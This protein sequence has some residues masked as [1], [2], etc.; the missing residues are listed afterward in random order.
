[1]TNCILCTPQPTQLSK[2]S[3]KEHRHA[4]ELGDSANSAV[5]EHTWSVNHAVDLDNTND[6]GHQCNLQ[7]YL[8]EL[9]P[10]LPTPKASARIDTH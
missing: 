4:V 8:S 1:M 3:V 5:A 7:V 2:P 10:T 6:I 9:P